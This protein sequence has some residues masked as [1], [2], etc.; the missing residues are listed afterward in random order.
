MAKRARRASALRRSKILRAAR[1]YT[2]RKVG[3]NRVALMYRRMSTVELSCEC[4]Q[5]GGYRVEIDGR[6]ITCLES[7]CTGSCGWVVNVPG[8]RGGFGGVVLAKR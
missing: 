3:R 1:G 4:S 8:I 2:F 7:G 5:S 6:S